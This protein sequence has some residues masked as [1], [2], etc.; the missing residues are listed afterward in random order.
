MKEKDYKNQFLKLCLNLK[1]GSTKKDI[2][3]HN[4]SMKGL[5]K[6]FYKVQKIEDKSFYLELLHEDSIQVRLIA[7]AHC[8]GLNIYV[9]D[10]IKTLS[11]IAN[12]KINNELAF[13]AQATLDVWKQQG[14]LTF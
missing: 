5:S 6:I 8:L 11:N 2:I 14:Y 7:A 9:E 4:R 12:N 10:A 3:V 13:D 1:Q